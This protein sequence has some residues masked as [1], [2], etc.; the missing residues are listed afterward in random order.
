MENDRDVVSSRLLITPEAVSTRTFSTTRRGYQPDEVKQFLGRVAD[1]LAAA[2]AREAELRRTLQEALSRAAHPE[3]DEHALTAAL[4]D[5]A[6]RLIASARETAAAIVAEAEKRAVQLLHDAEVRA[7]RL[8][9]E[10]E[11]LMARRVDEA[12]S[13]ATAIRQAAEVEVKAA[14]D[15]AT[16]ESEAAVSS[17]RAQGKEMVGEARAVRERMLSDL[18]RRRRSAQVQI[19][20][21]RAGRDRLLAAYEVVRRSLDEVTRELDA[22]EPEARLAAEEVGRRAVESDI[23]VRP[24]PA[25]PPRQQAAIAAPRAAAPVLTPA[26][27]EPAPEVAVPVLVGSSPAAPV[28]RHDDPGPKA[29][30]LAPPRPPALRPQSVAEAA[31]VRARAVPFAQPVA[32]PEPERPPAPVPDL[33]TG[34]NPVVEAPTR[35]VEDLFARIRQEVP[36]SPPEP[37]ADAPPPGA[38]GVSDENALSGRDELLD[39]VEAELTRA[40]KRVLQDEQNEVLDQLRRTRSTSVEAVLPD[41]AA[42]RARYADAATSFLGRAAVAGAG[43][44]SGEGSPAAGGMAGDLA[45]QL[46]E[47]LRSRLEQALAQGTG[48]EGGLNESI[49]SIYRQWK[50][51]HIEPLARHAAA[52]AFARGRFEAT[53]VGVAL[54]WVVDDEGG[55]CPD[56]DDNALAGPVPRGEAFPTGQP[57]PPAHEG[58]RCLLVPTVP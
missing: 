48:D 36:G 30:V 20:Q 12:E 5:H 37:P 6:G 22:A 50:V 24:E 2:G 14:R 17:A 8:R 34:Q 9:D 26:P 58:C 33:G 38:V 3:L 32:Q 19:D 55:R 4:G 49:S 18:T 56:C 11:G 16:A 15:K 54:R 13:A 44:A 40:L 46:V 25:A 47:P 53:P 57:H 35:H 28:S 39:P 1:E 31:P 21:L 51:Q 42:Q 41:A 29:A 52:A 45:R 7:G 27:A 10:S 23:A 43:G